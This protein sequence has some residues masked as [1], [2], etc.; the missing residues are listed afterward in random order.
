MLFSSQCRISGFPKTW[1]LIG[2]YLKS[3]MKRF[4][5]FIW[6]PSSEMFWGLK[7]QMYI[8]GTDN[9]L[10]FSIVWI[11]P[12]TQNY[13]IKCKYKIHF[14]VL[15]CALHIYFHTF[16]YFLFENDHNDWK[17]WLIHN[18][19]LR[20]Y[21]YMCSFFIVLAVAAAQSDYIGATLV[22]SQIWGKVGNKQSNT[23]IMSPCNY[24]ITDCCDLGWL[25]PHMWT[26]EYGERGRERK[27]RGRERERENTPSLS[28]I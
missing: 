4:H 21:S 13:L 27:E 3:F 11:D 1:I 17:D 15:W 19:A 26:D 5:V 23:L 18:V 20:Y 16:T 7:L 12:L 8:G 24:C 2:F 9:N 6:S 28:W 22:L 25:C 14:Q 10:M